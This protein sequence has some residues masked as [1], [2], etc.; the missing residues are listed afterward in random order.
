MKEMRA[1]AIREGSATLAHMRY[2]MAEGIGQAK[3]L[4]REEIQKPN[5]SDQLTPDNVVAKVLEVSKSSL[6]PRYCNAH[7]P[8]LLSPKLPCRSCTVVTSYLHLFLDLRPSPV[9]WL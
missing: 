4:L 6:F 9:A 3:S 5:H 2:V 7:P 8:V 1:Q